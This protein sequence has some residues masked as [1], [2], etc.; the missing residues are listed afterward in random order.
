M[1]FVEGGDVKHGLCDKDI[2]PLSILW[3]SGLQQCSHLLFINGVCFT[4]LTRK[5]VPNVTWIS[6]LPRIFLPIK[7]KYESD[8]HQ[9]DGFLLTC[10]IHD[11]DDKDKSDGFLLNESALSDLVVK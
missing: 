8:F 10:E 4:L 1:Y 5:V 2:C 9:Q 7:F 6:D 11:F 3:E